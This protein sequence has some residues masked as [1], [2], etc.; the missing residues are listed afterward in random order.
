MNQ[1]TMETLIQRLERVERENRR[2][3]RA[4][5]I[6][7]AAIAAVVLLGL[8]VPGK[9]AEEKAP[10]NQVV[11]ESDSVPVFPRMDTTSNMVFTLAR[12]DLVEIR[13]VV[14]AGQVLWCKIKE[15]ASGGRLGYVHCK[16]LTG[17]WP[18]TPAPPTVTGRPK[19]EAPPV[20]VGPPEVPQASP[21]PPRAPA[22]A[23]KPVPK[24]MAK[25]TE[26][27][28]KREKR[29]TLQVASLGV[30]R[31]ALTLK[32][33]LEGLGYNPVIRMTT[34]PITRHRVYAGEF[35]S[36][37]EAEKTARSLNVDGFPSNLVEIEGGKF[38][39][40]V[41]SSFHLNEAID[42]ARSL[43][44]KNYTSKIDSETAPTPV[45]QVRIGEYENRAEAQKAV[46]ALKKEG[47]TPL[48]VRQ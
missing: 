16:N 18:P 48:M 43:R 28:I 40:E 14:E 11:V 44:K 30:E 27:E 35:S 4:G 8:A 39:L 20:V 25:V 19:E 26:P 24:P 21:K 3:K 2:L 34:V 17:E 37:E 31:N 6:A 7:F 10:L 47:F 13:V 5:V 23:E 22:V 38:R 42:L 45:H 15:V 29:Y 36:R 33:Q 12:G 41:G 46:E 32:K 9:A 1:P